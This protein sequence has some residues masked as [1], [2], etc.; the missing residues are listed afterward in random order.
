MDSTPRPDRPRIFGIGLN[1]TGSTSFHEAMTIL[2][3]ESLHWGGHET[4]LS[5]VAAKDAG[6]PLLAHL[7]PRYDAFSDITILSRNYA[8]LDEQYPGSRFVLTVRPVDDWIDS[9]R[10]HVENNQRNK[11]AGT[12]DGSFLVVDEDRW[13]REWSD[14]VSA[15]RAYFDGRDDFREIDITSGSGWRPFCTL[16]GVPE[17]EEPFPWRSPLPP[18]V[19]DPGRSP[20]SESDRGRPSRRRSLIRRGPRRRPARFGRGA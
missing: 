9:R 18:R 16:L 20:V 13:R 2:G 8:L 15:V 7:D 12:Y 6:L 3:Y 10:R 19:P 1:K 17:P 11:A 14:H 5:V 4:Y